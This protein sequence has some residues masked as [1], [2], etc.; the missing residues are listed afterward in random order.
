[1]LKI[2]QSL[3]F[4][5]KQVI[6]NSSDKIINKVDRTLKIHL[7][8]KLVTIEKL[9]CK[10][11]YWL[12][13][14]QNKHEPTSKHT[15]EN[16]YKDFQDVQIWPRIYKLTFSVIRET[17]LQSFQYKIINRIIACNKW[18]YD[19]KIKPSKVCKFCSS[20]DSIE[21]FFFYCHNAS[22]F[23]KFWINW[24]KRLTGVDI[25]KCEHLHLCLL[26]GF[27][28][29]GDDGFVHSLNYSVIV[30]KYHIYLT[31]MCDSNNLDFYNYLTLLKQKLKFEHQVSSNMSEMLAYILS[32][33]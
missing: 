33:M 10:D 22:Q 11:Y 4:E 23:W 29:N 17:K 12:L 25:S 8:N 30:A 24:W 31:K 26:F 2:R 21:H 9:K 27:P 13:I 14:N 16:I 3:P 6:N 1:M 5:W 28:G 18:L 15:W 20:E 32:E 19:I 7:N